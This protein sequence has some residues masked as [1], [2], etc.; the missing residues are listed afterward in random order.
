[1]GAA[2]LMATSAVGPGFLTQTVV[3]TQ[4]LGASFGF[5]ILFSILLDILVQTNIWRIIVVAKKR[6]QDIA[7]VL[8]PGLGY[9]IAGM[10]ALGGLAF[11]IGNIGGAGLGV[12]VLFPSLDPVTGAAISTVV[13]IALFLF[14]S[15]D[16]L[17]DRFVIS[18]GSMLLAMMFYVLFSTAPPLSEAIYRA[19]LPEKFNALAIVTLVGGTVGGYISFAGAHRLLDAGVVGEEALTQVNRGSALAISA[20]SLIRIILFLATL[21]VL[22]QGIS[23]D[24]GNPAASLFL[25]AAG[26]LGHKLFGLVLWAASI[27]SVIGA[28]YTS[29]SFLKTLHPAIGRHSRSAIIAFILMSTIIFCVLGKPIMLLILAGAVNGFILPITLSVILL[30]ARKKSI[31]GNY[32]HP[33]WMSICGWLI[34]LLMVAMSLHALW[35]LLR[36]MIGNG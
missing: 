35:W 15:A 29:V 8:Y 19:V 9:V 22:S 17:M 24:A 30:A 20:A 3:F 28:A 7:N 21:G 27:T 16:R 31:V 1:M 10:V 14:K 33:M 18:M 13:A 2:F 5:V 25:Q 11:N 4:T 26:N 6:A 12:N 23:L 34:S 36:P 32:Q